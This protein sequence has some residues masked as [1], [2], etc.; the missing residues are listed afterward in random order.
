MDG[1]VQ[2]LDRSLFLLFLPFTFAQKQTFMSNDKKVKEFVISNS[3]LNHYGS[4]VL[5]SGI[6]LTQYKRNP[7]MLWMH[8][9]PWR[10]T[11]DEVMPIGTVV[12]LRIEGDNLIGTPVFDENDEFAR[13]VKAKWDAGI[14]RMVSAGLEVVE[15]SDDP[16]VLLPGQRY[17]TITKSKLLEVSI[18][19]IGA[20]DDAIQLYQKGNII[21]L[22]KGNGEMSFL[23]PVNNYLNSKK[24]NEIAL[25]LGLAETATE[26]EIISAIELKAQK[27]EALEKEVETLRGSSIALAV[28]AAIESRRITADKRD[29]FV[30]LGKNIGLDQLNKTLDCIT[31]VQK[32][33]GLINH[34]SGAEAEFKKLSDVPENKLVELRENNFE[35]YKRLY[36]AEY[37]VE[38]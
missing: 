8:N 6:D 35:E 26:A 15:Q 25:K 11:K 16:S 18:V 2:P 37:G 12:N 24:M 38:L 22:S 34:L 1:S 27:V 9:R 3:R 28:D 19:D 21:T 14:L 17:S 20:N 36:Q 7:I 10:G 32:P 30:A 4:R 5:T 13:T 23:K 31:P 33:S 29:H